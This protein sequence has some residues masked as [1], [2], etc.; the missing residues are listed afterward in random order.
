MVA[1]G[2]AGSQNEAAPA[3]RVAT[4]LTPASA[5]VAAA[6]ASAAGSSDPVALPT[7]TLPKGGGAIRGLGEK[8]D[9]APA[10]GTATLTVPIPISRGRSR[11]EPELSLRYD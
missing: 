8:F 11:F 1:N 9:V 3:G 10:T 5:A 2:G 4:P 6:P 7:V